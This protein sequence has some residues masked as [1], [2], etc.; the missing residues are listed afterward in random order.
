[1]NL[2]S[3][4]AVASAVAVAF[5]VLA[6][7]FTLTKAPQSLADWQDGSFYGGTAP[8][9]NDTVI[10]P[11]NMN[12]LVDDASIAF[13]G[14]LTRIKPMHATTSI[15][16]VNIANDQ[17][18]ACSVYYAKRTGNGDV[19]ARGQIIKTG[20]GQLT[21]KGTAESASSYWTNFDI[22]QGA[23]K[24][25]CD[26]AAATGYHHGRINVG[27]GGL[28]VL[29]ANEANVT[30]VNDMLALTGAGV[31][32]NGIGKAS[33]CRLMPWFGLNTPQ[34]FSG[35]IVGAIHWYANG[36]ELL[37]GTESTFT[38]SF[39]PYYNRSGLTSGITGVMKFGNPGE[40]SSIGTAGSVTLGEV[41]ARVLYLGTGETTSKAFDYGDNSEGKK[42]PGVID[43]G[44]TGGLTLT[45]LFTPN[46]WGL[47]QRL[48]LT[49]SNVTEC[50][51]SNNIA[52][53]GTT[54]GYVTKKGTGIWRL[55][56]YARNGISGIAVEE[57]TLRFDSI[58]NRGVAT[59]VGDGLVRSVDQVVSK[60]DPLPEVAY[61]FKLGTET[62]A[63]TFEFCGT[64]NECVSLDRP[65]ALAG[66]AT[67]KNSG[68]ILVLKGGVSALTAGPK[69][70]TLAGDGAVDG[71]ESIIANITNGAGTV[72]IV[73]EGAGTWFIDDG[74]GIAGEIAVKAG[75]LIFRG[76]GQGYEWFRWTLR[77]MRGGTLEKAFG[78]QPFHRVTEV[79]F[80]DKDGMRVGAGVVPASSSWGDYNVNEDKYHAVYRPGTCGFGKKLSMVNSVPNFANLFD[81]DK[82]TLG[83]FWNAIQTNGVWVNCGPV[84]ERT[85]SY[86]CLLVRLPKGSKAVTHFDWA[87]WGEAW[88]SHPKSYLLEGSRDGYVWKT[89]IDEDDSQKAS[90]ASVSFQWAYNQSGGPDAVAMGVPG[91]PHPNGQ[92]IT[93]FTQAEPV[94]ISNAVS[95][96]SGATLEAAGKVQLGNLK[97]DANGAGTVKGFS[98]AANGSVDV[99]NYNQ[100]IALPLTFTDC[101]GTENFAA[102]W[103]VKTDG[104]PRV[105]KKLAFKDG[106]LSVV[107]SG[108]ILVVK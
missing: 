17:D 29:G 9:A 88:D 58:A 90:S 87:R 30:V 77:G 22:Q 10:L 52:L 38:G 76:E 36:Y 85:D 94:V 32:S 1:M 2:R 98:F 49:G 28:L 64:T 20:A 57:G 40:P 50:V 25:Y 3:I 74:V 7:E 61:D 8:S 48:W 107:S 6:A 67:I 4:V 91:D 93:V 27:A 24:L 104:K 34:V 70:L 15:L 72:S 21:L 46:G 62:T 56:H 53:N 97:V 26:A 69:T 81:G 71:T 23:V 43:A 84:V 33:Q 19:D 65:I 80:F 5:P 106:V 108:L 100:T 83:G 86:V 54:R 45:G 59:S 96:A 63:G 60:S 68:K 16:T 41:G 47:N 12:A 51:I 105:S 89:L 79:G 92:E 11:A 95:V 35:K 66:D 99:L 37:T 39:R 14:S 103:S 73:K 31:V 101:T 42:Y 13:V 18:F 78:L 75:K 82:S 102:G 44:A 55:A